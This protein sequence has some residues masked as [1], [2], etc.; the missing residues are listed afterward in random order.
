MSPVFPVKGLGKNLQAQEPE[1][2]ESE[3][4]DAVFMLTC[5]R[6]KETI[7]SHSG[8]SVTVTSVLC[9]WFRNKYLLHC[10]PVLQA[11]TCL[12]RSLS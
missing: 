9:Q 11:L 2:V 12:F 8:P 6:K 4:L 3:G 10:A 1:E 5:I 7:C